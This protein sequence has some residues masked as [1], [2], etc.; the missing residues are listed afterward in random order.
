MSSTRRWGDT[1][2]RLAG[3]RERSER[4]A[5][6][7]GG[8]V[9][10][11]TGTRACV[12]THTQEATTAHF[13]RHQALPLILPLLSLDDFSALPQAGAARSPSRRCSPSNQTLLQCSGPAQHRRC[14]LQDFMSTSGPTQRPLPPLS[15]SCPCSANLVSLASSVPQLMHMLFPLP[16]KLS[17][18]IHLAN[19]MCPGSLSSQVI[20]S[21]HQV[22][23][24]AHGL[25]GSAHL[26]PT[27]GSARTAWI[28]QHHTG[29]RFSETHSL[30]PIRLSPD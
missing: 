4:E 21:E 8:C 3:E 19:S 22:I 17:S 6:A 28:S 26:P 12:H 16:G 14:G 27:P 11:H 25:R 20:F 23:P 5:P 13:P 7:P 9:H 15:L 18:L 24:S 30:C 2:A 1:G 10:T 29:L